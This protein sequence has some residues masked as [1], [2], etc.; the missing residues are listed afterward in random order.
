MRVRV[1]ASL[2]YCKEDSRLR[3]AGLGKGGM[4]PLRYGIALKGHRC[5]SSGLVRETMLLQSTLDPVAVDHVVR[6]R[7]SVQHVQLLPML[8]L[9]IPC[10]IQA[11]C[12]KRC[13][14]LCDGWPPRCRD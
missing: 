7:H 6:P 14:R 10:M 3:A 12:G 13:W 4:L 8:K 9:A 2:R 11:H 1:G 5:G